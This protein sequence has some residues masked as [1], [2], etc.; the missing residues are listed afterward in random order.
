MMSTR[1]CIYIYRERERE[2]ERERDVFEHVS[3]RLPAETVSNVSSAGFHTLA[4]HCKHVHIEVGFK[5]FSI[6]C[7]W[8]FKFCY[9]SLDICVAAFQP[10]FIVSV[11]RFDFSFGFFSKS[12]SIC[13]LC[14][15]FVCLFF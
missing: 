12:F 11:F 4:C 1:V 3:S 10:L 5:Q 15:S 2:R 8:P 14:T 7:S 6:S 9:V 13:F